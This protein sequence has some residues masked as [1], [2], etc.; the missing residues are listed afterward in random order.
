MTWE[1]IP[2]NRRMRKRKSEKRGKKPT[3]KDAQQHM[4]DKCHGEFLRDQSL[5]EQRQE[6]LKDKLKPFIVPPKEAQGHERRE[7]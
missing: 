1:N 3:W 7:A 4:L 6:Q 5:E 2:A